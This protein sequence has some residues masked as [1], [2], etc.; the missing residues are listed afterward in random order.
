[1]AKGHFQVDNVEHDGICKCVYTSMIECIASRR[2]W[3]LLGHM[4]VVKIGTDEA[5]I[6]MFMLK[7]Y[8]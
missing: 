6:S 4:N 7:L 1:M 3:Q 2:T 8:V 5:V